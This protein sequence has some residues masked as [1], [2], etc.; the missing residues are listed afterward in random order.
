ERV[1]GR[2]Y[3]PAVPVHGRAFSAQG[4]MQPKIRP[5]D[6][7]HIGEERPIE[8]LEDR[9]PE[10]ECNTECDREGT[11]LCPHLRRRCRRSCCAR[12][13]ELGE[14]LARIEGLSHD[15]TPRK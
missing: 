10:R 13:V 9:V 11:E 8:Q 5:A 3:D 15:P 1:D 4:P 12:A 14:S 2:G 7:G 6:R